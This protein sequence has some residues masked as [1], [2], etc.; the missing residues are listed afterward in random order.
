MANKKNNKIGEALESD[1][2]SADIVKISSE[3]ISIMSVEDDLNFPSVTFKK[4]E[5]VNYT[6]E[7][8]DELTKSIP[9]IARFIEL[10]VLKIV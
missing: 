1:S 8:F 5:T 3:E 10:G 6:R 4:G 7:A 9:N 2:S